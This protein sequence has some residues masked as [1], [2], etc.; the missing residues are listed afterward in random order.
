MLA[1][2][3]REFVTVP[4][5]APGRY[6]IA[7]FH[8]DSRVEPVV[9]ATAEVLAG[10]TT[11]VDL[12]AT[13]AVMMGRVT[14]GGEPVV[15]ATVSL[16]SVSQRTDA[17]G[18]FRLAFGRRPSKRP[19]YAPGITVSRHGIEATFLVPTTDDVTLELGRRH[20]TIDAVDEAG[21]AVAVAVEL[22]TIQQERR[23]DGLR[24]CSVERSLP[25]QRGTRIG[26]LPDALLH[27]TVVFEGGVRV[28]L[29]M[30][31]G[32]DASTVVR[33]A[34]GI[35]RLQVL[36]SA[37]ASAADI[38]VDAWTWRGAGEPPADD[39]EIR[40]GEGR[41]FRTARTDERGVVEF[42]VAAGEVFLSILS[43]SATRRLSVAPGT[44]TTVM[45][46]VP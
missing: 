44:T 40:E 13:G 29:S 22:Q 16:D 6:E 15:G 28:P 9:L 31:S 14:S 23:T 19:S 5:L 17:F 7:Q 35:V 38:T 27:G 10:R 39:R 30:P 42:A 2:V 4:G 20:V 18:M 11:W 25:A 46:T 3:D 43:D 12:R 34:T 37:E 1:I 36:R 24:S 33:P 41:L 26:P 45:L 32:T 21:G 8:S